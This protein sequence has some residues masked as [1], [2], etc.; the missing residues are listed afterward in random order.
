MKKHYYLFVLLIAFL[1]S[2]EQ[3]NFNPNDSFLK[4]YDDKD[5]NAEY[6]PVGIGQSDSMLFVLAERSLTSSDFAGIKIIKTNAKG[7]FIEE[8]ELEEQFVAPTPD[9]QKIGNTHYFFCMDKNTLSPYLVAIDAQG[10]LSTSPT[11]ISNSYPLAVS[12]SNQNEL[13]LL[14]YDQEA[15]N[16]VISLINTA[17]Q[18]T[19]TA[20]YSIGA[21]N[22]VLEPIISHFT[23]KDKRLPFFCGQ[24]PDQKFFFNA[25]YNYTLST[26]FTELGD[27]PTGVLQGQADD[28]G[29]KSLL[30][31]AANNFA[32]LAF[33]FG[34]TYA[35]SSTTINTSAISSS[36]NLLDRKLPEV[37]KGSTTKIISHNYAG[38]EQIIMAAET[39]GRQVVLYFYQASNGELINTYF[40]GTLNP[41]TFSDISSLEDGSLLIVGTTFLAD[42]FERVFIQK[43]G[44]EQ[45]GDI[46]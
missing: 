13:I 5:Y 20:A 3:E 36:I 34:D 22:E 16:S 27:E 42:R 26:V 25:F 37:K 11:G 18:V 12:V 1:F 31:I 41:F 46:L 29:L 21:G 43:I 15:K 32:F 17:G 9:L 24:S 38:Q 14:S 4:I 33:Q 30:P 28:A 6:F 35:S 39:E 19:N 45:L 7:D 23:E 2:C 8:T 10:N 40:L 44:K